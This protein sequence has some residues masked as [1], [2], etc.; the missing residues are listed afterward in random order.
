VLAEVLSANQ[1]GAVISTGGGV[2]ET[3][4]A[5]EVLQRWPGLRIQLTRPIEV[6]HYSKG[7][8]TCAFYRHVQDVVAYLS[9]DT[10]RPSLGA[11]V[12]DLWN[13]RRPLYT[14]CTTHEFVIRRGETDW[15]KTEEE[16]VRFTR[17]L[18]SP[19]P[20]LPPAPSFFLCLTFPDLAL[21]VGT[22]YL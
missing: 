8:H 14:E 13:K 1:K 2:V 18:L 21:V 20:P 11:E 4:R 5:R 16:F 9:S 17:R 6:R 7:C 19:L 12:K 3:G 15:T 22:L 10:S